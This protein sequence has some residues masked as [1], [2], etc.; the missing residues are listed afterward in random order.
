V[1]ISLEFAVHPKAS[2]PPGSSIRVGTPLGARTFFIT[3]PGS[4]FSGP[5][6]MGPLP[7]L[8]KLELDF[9]IGKRPISMM[10][11]PVPDDSQ[12]ILLVLPNTA[13]S[14]KSQLI[15]NILHP[16]KR[17]AVA[18]MPVARGCTVTCLNDGA[19]SGDGD[20][21]V[22]CENDDAIVKICC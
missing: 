15:G 5:Q 17:S 12:L 7:A 19:K 6:L 3:A 22:E 20:C 10:A 14:N 1:A 11:D 13:S 2:L 16:A 4:G 18:A 21:C 8:F 9:E